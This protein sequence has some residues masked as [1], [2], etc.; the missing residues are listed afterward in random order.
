MHIMSVDDSR[1]VH[2]YL[3]ETF[4]GT[5]TTI[6]HYF[7][8]REAVDAVSKPGIKPPDIVLLDWEMPVMSGIEALPTLRAKL[9]NTIIIMATSKNAI[10]DIVSALEKGASDYIM[11]PFTKDILIG[12]IEQLLGRKVA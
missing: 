11:K 3:T 4:E 9:P 6:E 12:K 10:S 7:N 8:G 1:A 2:A 5:N